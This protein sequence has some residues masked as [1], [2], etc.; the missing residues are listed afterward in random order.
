MNSNSKD[1]GKSNRNNKSS[2]NHSDVS[3]DSDSAHGV[4]AKPSAMNQ[5]QDNQEEHELIMEKQIQR[6][7]QEKP[8]TAAKQENSDKQQS[9]PA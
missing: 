7:A 3:V 4:T 8:T 1:K 5:S 2:R 6:H 9:D